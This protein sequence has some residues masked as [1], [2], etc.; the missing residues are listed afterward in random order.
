MWKR[1]SAV[2]LL[3]AALAC[4]ADLPRKAP[5]FAISLPNG[6][7]LHLN[8]Y[9]GKVVVLAFILTTCPHCQ[10]AVRCLIEDQKQYGPRGLQVVASA[11]EQNAQS[12]VPGFVKSFQPPFPVG[13]NNPYAAIAFMQHPP[14]LIP[15]MPLIAFID[16]HGMIRNQAEGDSPMFIH[17][18]E[19]AANLRAE[20]E[21]M[22]AEGA[23]KK[24]PV[25][26]TAAHRQAN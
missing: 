7:Q 24:A 25:K 26:R 22:L 6:S 14:M 1:A 2:L 20:I 15:H 10:H 11:I 8:Q 18:E 19:V 5:D 4:A 17:D 16:R 21:K 13:F 9:Q 12:A 23:P 3:V